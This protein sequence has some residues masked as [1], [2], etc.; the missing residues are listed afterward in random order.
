MPIV[1]YNGVREWSAPLQ[2]ADL[3]EP[4]PG[5][6]RYLPRFEYLVIDEGHLPREAL[7][8]LDSP[9]AGVFQLEQS[10]G[11]EEIRRIIDTLIE[12][13]D[14]PEMLELR[15][16][17]TTWIRR[18]ILQARLPGVTIP[19]LQDLQEAKKMLAER[20]AEWPRQW[21]AEG[22]EKGRKKGRRE[23]RSS[24]LLDGQRLALAELVEEKFGAL[25]P[26]YAALIAKASEDRLR[27]WLKQIL[28]AT[29]PD[30]L[31]QS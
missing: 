27:L 23:G 11:L 3:I 7:E 25:D 30:D 28:R 1:L 5:F 2:V 18:V 13:L 8:P 4:L 29:K 22:F 21:M 15:R 14:D 9:V 19:E 10:S 31:F 17:M 6:E 24:G 16:D 26:R 20:A 12:V